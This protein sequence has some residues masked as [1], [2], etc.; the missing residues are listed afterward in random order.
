MT[1]QE[2][3][4]S[5]DPAGMLNV[6]AV[7]SSCGAIDSSGGR[8]FP[9][10]SLR[11]LRL[12]ACACARQVWEQLTDDAP[13]GRC[14]GEGS[15]SGGPGGQVVGMEP[16]RKCLICSGTG[17]INRSRRAVEVAERY[18]DGLAT[19]DEFLRASMDA[20]LA[21]Q[22]SP[23][24][25]WNEQT[26]DQDKDMAALAVCN[27]FQEVAANAAAE[28]GRLAQFDKPAQVALL[29]CIA[30]NPWRPVTLPKV[31][32][33]KGACRSCAGSGEDQ[34]ESTYGDCPVC[35][36][37]G[38]EEEGYCPW[39]THNDGAVAKLARIAYEQRDWSLLPLIADAM[40]EAG[41]SSEAKCLACYGTDRLD[42]DPPMRGTIEC[43]ACEPWGSGKRGTN[44]ILAHLRGQDVFQHLK[45]TRT[46]FAGKCPHCGG[47][48]WESGE[49][50]TCH[51]CM[52]SHLAGDREVVAVPQGL[53]ARGCHVI[54]ALLG[55]S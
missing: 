50:N 3:L 52:V 49:Y 20:V 6:F 1:E 51:T 27:L 32:L 19:R 14:K 28:T 36:G 55:L 2:W 25:P 15:V 4:A 26:P 33:Y 12:F 9:K 38:N 42:A 29:R 16:R 31:L 23:F 40:E 46:I 17:R 10:T 53:H 44:P 45:F 22:Q 43:R 13:C 35:G 54:D 7:N 41:C 47:R 5:T 21:R 39:L 48:Q 24:C 8:F 37:T 30:G 34:R 18:A 11:K